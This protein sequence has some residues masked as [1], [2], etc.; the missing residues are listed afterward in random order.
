MTRD[1]AGGVPLN[2]AGIV[3]L[4]SYREGEQASAS[5]SLQSNP[6]PPVVVAPPRYHR[7][8]HRGA[9]HAKK[10]TFDT[11][12]P[13]RA[14]NLS[15]EYIGNT[16]V[17]SDLDYNIGS[18]I[19]NYTRGYNTGNLA[20][21]TRE[22]EAITPST[23]YL[24]YS[25]PANQA[26]EYA[27]SH[28]DSPL[29]YRR[30]MTSASRVAPQV[31]SDNDL[32]S[33]KESKIYA[34]DQPAL[35]SRPPFTE[36]YT[37]ASVSGDSRARLRGA[38]LNVDS[39]SRL[40][41]PPSLQGMPINLE[42]QS[43]LRSRS[44]LQGPP[45]N[46]E[47]QPRLMGIHPLPGIP[48]NVDSGARL[49]SIQALPVAPV[50]MESGIRLSQYPLPNV[51]VD[52]RVRNSSLCQLPTGVDAR[53]PSNAKIDRFSVPLSEQVN[54][55]APGV[56]ALSDHIDRF[57]RPL[58]PNESVTVTAMQP[59][60]PPRLGAVRSLITL[61]AHRPAA[62]TPAPAIAPHRMN[63][64]STLPRVRLRDDDDYPTLRNHS[65][66][67][68]VRPALP[69]DT[70]ASRGTPSRAASVHPRHGGLMSGETSDTSQAYNKT[71]FVKRR[72]LNL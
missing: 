45:I 28:V 30:T 57:V 23:S 67:V 5:A 3:S 8:S 35:Y 18:P 15:H 39:G 40:R 31:Y 33:L 64:F 38:S 11:P 46:V 21:S 4:T 62:P 63:T 44:S 70:D 6:P 26:R 17:N 65:S 19:A 69:D 54:P 43:R 66:T 10:V 9:E 50:R 13:R 68:A 36:A 55:A 53:Y 60:I 56:D 42:S 14:A 71:S 41:G 52:S 51:P 25:T 47:S 32:V 7:T 61:P 59:A 24:E 58:H 34:V 27:G 72:R 48:L 20:I 29:D 49:R 12:S 16:V 22:Y 2:H 37:G 1:P